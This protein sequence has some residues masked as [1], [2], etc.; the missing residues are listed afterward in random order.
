MELSR[1]RL[2]IG[3]HVECVHPA[4]IEPG[5]GLAP[6]KLTCQWTPATVSVED[7][8]W[9]SYT[10]KRMAPQVGF[11]PTTLRL[12]A[13]QGKNL[14]PYLSVAYGRAHSEICP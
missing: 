14:K 8:N 2:R 4:S 9:Q 11:E 3:F 13:V 10:G 7:G 5:G 12:T 1:F 6:D